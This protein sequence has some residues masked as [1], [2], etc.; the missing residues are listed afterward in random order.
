[1]L[2]LHKITRMSHVVAYSIAFILFYDRDGQGG[3]F[4]VMKNDRVL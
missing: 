1:M 4:K 2:E 3:M